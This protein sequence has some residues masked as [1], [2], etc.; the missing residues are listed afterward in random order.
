MKM[1][2]EIEQPDGIPFIDMSKLVCRTRERLDRLPI[3]V[4]GLVFECSND[5]LRA[6]VDTAPLGDVIGSD[7][8]TELIY[9][10]KTHP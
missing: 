5:I 2:G 3:T 1:L 9:Q 4:S 6:G 7:E 10:S 8:G